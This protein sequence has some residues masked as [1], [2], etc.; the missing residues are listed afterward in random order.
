MEL[1]PLYEII[2]N[3]RITDIIIHRGNSP[4]EAI[5]PLE[6]VRIYANAGFKKIEIDIYAT[7]ESTYKFCHPLDR[8]KINEV[9]NIDDGFLESVVKQLPEVEWYVDLKCL[10]LDEVP[11]KLLQ[12]LIDVFGNSGIITAAQP[13]IIQFAH[14]QK[15]ETAQYFKDNISSKLNYEPNFFVQNESDSNSYLKGKTIVYC[16]EPKAAL[17]CLDEGFAG[18]MVDGDKLIVS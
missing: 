6:Q 18:A 17:N 1:K 2:I 9:H 14:S 10:D 7:S 5:E 13:E 12:H 11:V 3:M 8:D 16:L 15:Q 4:I